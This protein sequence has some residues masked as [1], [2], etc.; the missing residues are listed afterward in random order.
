MK[1]TVEVPLFGEV[2]SARMHGA[3]WSVVCERRD[4]EIPQYQPSEATQVLSYRS[5]AR[6]A[7]VVFHLV[8]GSSVRDS[9]QAI[10]VEECVYRLV[11]GRDMKAVHPFFERAFKAMTPKMGDLSKLNKASLKDEAMPASFI[12]AMHDSNAPLHI[13]LPLEKGRTW[14]NEKEITPQLQA[15]DAWMERFLIIGD[16]LMIREDVPMLVIA[17]DAD[18]PMVEVVRGD[19]L[20]DPVTMN[21]SIG[22][23]PKS[24]GYFGMDEYETALDHAA[25]VGGGWLTEQELQVDMVSPLI[26]GKPYADMSVVD[27]AEGMRKRFVRRIASVSHDAVEN[28]AE[29]EEALATI[30]VVTFALFK[31]LVLGLA[32]WNDRRS[33]AR[34]LRV[35]PSILADMN[36]RKVFFV[37]ERLAKIGDLTLERWDARTV[38]INALAA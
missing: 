22:F 28:F 17:G 13:P 18:F 16:R 7:P 20:S 15:F 10:S 5:N 12:E 1:I 23:M 36:A 25:A 2:T 19:D 3:K 21:T 6:A 32:E 29:M 31:E 34:I 4:Y 8:D 35:V 9:G 24:F 14:W 30:D 11:V 26:P 38:D 27:M 37:T 33:T